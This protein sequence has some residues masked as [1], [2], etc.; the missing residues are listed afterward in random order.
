MKDY[1]KIVEKDIW[2]GKKP[3][4]PSMKSI[5]MSLTAVSGYWE[6]MILGY[7]FMIFLVFPT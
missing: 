3:K 5:K 4:K 7:S 1:L 6:S 2:I